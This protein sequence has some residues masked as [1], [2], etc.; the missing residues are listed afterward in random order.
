MPIDD[1]SAAIDRIN[2]GAE[3]ASVEPSLIGH[4]WQAIS[5][6]PKEQRWGT[7]VGL[8]AVALGDPELHTLYFLRKRPLLR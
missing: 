4:L 6:I 5:S 8:H 2:A 7:G 3:I 1:L